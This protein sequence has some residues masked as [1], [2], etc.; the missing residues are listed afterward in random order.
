MREA[1]SRARRALI[2]LALLIVALVAAG[3]AGISAPVPT[4]APQANTPA[5]SGQPTQ[6]A[7][8]AAPA[9]AKDIPVGVDA[10]GNFYRGDPNAAVKLVEWSDF[11]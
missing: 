10:A 1:E 3:C 4:P 6:A 7:G 9:T 8:P 5:P 11:Q 2:P